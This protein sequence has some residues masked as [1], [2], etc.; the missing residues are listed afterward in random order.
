MAA[1]QHYRATCAGRRHL[2][3]EC[4][5]SIHAQDY[6]QIEI[7]V[8]EDGS[9]TAQDCVEQFR[10]ATELRVQYHPI[11]KNGRCRRATRASRRLRA[12]C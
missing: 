2:L 4:L 12:R 8:V 7:V 6:R 5:R 3:L 11:A 1:G 9:N 10:T